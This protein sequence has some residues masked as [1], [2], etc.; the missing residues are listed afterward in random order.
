[1]SPLL[2]RMLVGLAELDR[3]LLRSRDLPF[4]SSVLVAAT[5]PLS[6]GQAHD[7]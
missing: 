7:Q 1:V 5:K 6:G 2:E 4:G 3:S